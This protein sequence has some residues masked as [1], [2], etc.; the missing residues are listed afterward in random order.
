[1]RG[2]A[3]R[4]HIWG[5]SER[6]HSPLGSSSRGSC[7]LLAAEVNIQPDAHRLGVNL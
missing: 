6:E 4:R 1:M 3:N 5:K 7:L 2:G